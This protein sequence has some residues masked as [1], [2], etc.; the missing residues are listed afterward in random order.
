MAFM[1][2]IRLASYAVAGAALII[3]HET[4]KGAKEKL[5]QWVV[6]KFTSRSSD[7]APQPPNPCDAV[8]E[9][10]DFVNGGTPADIQE[11][12][13]SPVNVTENADMADPMAED[14]NAV[15]SV[16]PAHLE[17]PT[18]TNV[19]V[20]EKA[21]E[22]DPTVEH[23]QSNQDNAVNV[24]LSGEFPSHSVA[25][26]DRAANGDLTAEPLQRHGAPAPLSLEATGVH[27]SVDDV[28][29]AV[30]VG[31]TRAMDTSRQTKSDELAQDAPNPDPPPGRGIRGS[32]V[33]A[34]VN[35]V[36]G[37]ARS[38]FNFLTAKN[39]GAL[40]PRD[41]DKMRRILENLGWLAVEQ[42]FL[43]RLFRRYKAGRK[44]YNILKNNTPTA[45]CW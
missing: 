3:T 36:K 23:S 33:A 45:W 44:V 29:N 14:D 7:P 27:R 13:P 10:D 6:D 31:E 26:S 5:R 37:W 20:T 12:T 35:A 40:D 11:P 30:K 41:R 25:E 24:P 42:L 43:E 34:A 8:N 17:E 18:L 2:G 39:G 16:R 21:V 19:N 22:G 15:N 38:L 28:D 4:T 32:F 1:M 9:E